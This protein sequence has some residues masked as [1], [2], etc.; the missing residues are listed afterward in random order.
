ML[1]QHRGLQVLNALHLTPNKFLWC[2]T[3]V[4]RYLTCIVVVSA[5]QA[6]VVHM[7]FEFSPQ[8]K[9]FWPSNSIPAL[10]NRTTVII[11]VFQR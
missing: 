11:I 5:L 7:F 8:S 4:E 9:G 2:K 6:H 10:F 3:V 1:A